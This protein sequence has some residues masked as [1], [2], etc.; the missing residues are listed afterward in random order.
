MED[1]EVALCDPFSRHGEEVVRSRYG[2]DVRERPLTWPQIGMSIED[3][4]ETIVAKV[5][6]VVAGRAFLEAVYYPFAEFGNLEVIPAFRGKGLASRIVADAVK[7]ASEMGFLALHL[8]TD[9]DNTAAHRLYVRHGLMPAMQGKM[10]KLIRFLNYPALFHLL[11]EH[12]LALFQSH[13]VERLDEHVWELAWTDPLS[14]ESL[15]IGL[16]GGS[17]Q[18]DSNGFGPGVKCFQLRSG[19]VSLRTDIVGPCV[20]SK[21]QTFDVG[22]EVANLGSTELKGTCRLLLNPGFAPGSETPGSAKFSVASNAS[23]K[24]SLPVKILESFDDEILNPKVSSFPSVSIAVEVFLGDHV[25]WLS[26]QLKVE[27]QV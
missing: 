24:V 17:C 15:S 1:I 5:N 11:W 22:V 20:V 10:L 9:L 12:P 25:F 23:E 26:S 7:R 27:H 3:F 8:Q 13:P 19:D 16:S 4:I 18:A 14:E 6:G 21:G 2:A